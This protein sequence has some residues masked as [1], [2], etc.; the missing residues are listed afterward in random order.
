MPENQHL[1]L[2]KVLVLSFGF[3][4]LFTAFLSCQNITAKIMKDLG[5][6]GLG[7]INLAIIYLSFGC[8]SLLASRINDKFG[9]RLTLCFSGLTYALWV[10]SFLLPAYK[11]EALQNGYTNEELVSDNVIIVVTLTSAFLIGLGAGPLWVSQSF[12]LTEC[13]NDLNKG[14]YNSLFYGI[15]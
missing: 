9:T 15:F 7:F 1:N 2:D 4:I 5:F 6:E 14:R 8:N 11:Y 13:A 12:Y 3:V 10:A